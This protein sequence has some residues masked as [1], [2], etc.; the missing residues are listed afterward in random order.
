MVHYLRLQTK[1]QLVIAWMDLERAD[2]VGSLV[3]FGVK[4]LSPEQD[5]QEKTCGLSMSVG[6]NISCTSQTDAGKS[7]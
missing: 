7:K 5:S 4:Y 1:E 3:Q 6:S 2:Q